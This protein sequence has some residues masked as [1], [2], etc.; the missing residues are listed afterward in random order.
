M[1]SFQ[2][3]DVCTLLGLVVLGEFQ[4]TIVPPSLLIA[5]IGNKVGNVVVDEGQGSGSAIQ[6]VCELSMAFEPRDLDGMMTFVGDGGVNGLPQVP[7][8]VETERLLRSHGLLCPGT[9]GM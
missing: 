3:M 6:Q 8:L 7:I 4:G 5:E 2:E 1:Y 9:R